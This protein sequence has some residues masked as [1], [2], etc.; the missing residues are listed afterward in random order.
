MPESTLTE[1]AVQERKYLLEITGNA[2]AVAV[3]RMGGKIIRLGDCLI[4]ELSYQP[5]V[6]WVLELPVKIVILIRGIKWQGFYPT[7]DDSTEI[8]HGMNSVFADGVLGA[9]RPADPEHKAV[10][11]PEVPL[12]GAELQDLLT[13]LEQAGFKL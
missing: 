13:K 3:A 6:V 7:W 4:A 12:S 9:L 11:P 8:S 5:N 10:L 1:E 2:L